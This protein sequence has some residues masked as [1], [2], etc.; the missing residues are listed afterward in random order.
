MNKSRCCLPGHCHTHGQDIKNVLAVS[1]LSYE[2]IILF[3]TKLS[4]T[5]LPVSN[6]SSE[7]IIILLQPNLV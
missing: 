4:L 2:L 5:I 6:I 7:L 1:I 3:G